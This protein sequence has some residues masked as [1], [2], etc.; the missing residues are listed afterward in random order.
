MH[1]VKIIKEFL[2]VDKITIKVSKLH[3]EISTDSGII[4][5]VDDVSFHIEK[6]KVFGL[7]GESGSG[8]TMTAMSILR[9]VPPPG[10][11][12]MG[13]IDFEGKNLLN[14]TKK[15]MESIRGNRIG[16]IFQE[17]MTALNPVIR[18]GEQIGETIAFHGNL[19]R[20]DVK[21]RVLELLRQVGFEDPEKR[22]I[23][24]PHQLSGGQR[25]RILI[26]MA[27]SCNPSLLIADEP[28]TAL[29]VATESQI[30]YL[31]KELILGY[32]MSML[33][34]THN[35]NIM[36][37]FG[38]YIGIMYAGRLL[39]EAAVDDFFNEPLHPYS[40]GLMESIFAFKGHEKRLKAIPGFVPRLSDLPEGCK[41]NPRCMYAMPRCRKDEPEVKK[42]GNERWVRC[43]LYQN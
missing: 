38:D 32:G 11:I 29:D 6:G 41:F 1:R 18:I 5:A 19:S 26:A 7:I 34:I 30:L 33:F 23:Q 10:R 15:E 28:T 9:L 39:E 36:R 8:K 4:K 43:Y 2:K 17:P 27:I 22:Y 37:R 14:L 13:E 24:Y 31:L 20:S 3:T 40:R 35:L 16:M 25:Q 21:K 42:I 12:V